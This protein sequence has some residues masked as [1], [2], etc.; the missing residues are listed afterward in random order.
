MRTLLTLLI[1]LTCTNA[2]AG[3]SLTN[4]SSS[5]VEHNITK[6]SELLTAIDTDQAGKDEILLFVST[7]RS[8]IKKSEIIDR[9]FNN[10]KIFY[11]LGDELSTEAEKA[12]KDFEFYSGP[13]IATKDL[14]EIKN[15]L[16]RIID[17]SERMAVIE[18]Q[19]AIDVIREAKLASQQVIPEWEL[20][21]MKQAAE[22]TRINAVKSILKEAIDRKG[23]PV[24]ASVFT[25]SYAINAGG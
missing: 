10:S 7:Q 12:L 19:H 6:A 5:S 22:Q 16:K 13:L 11:L 20:E 24:G 8:A 15:I 2:Y 18:L 9:V 23:V 21:A 1:V 17:N 3:I 25:G 4:I 14:S